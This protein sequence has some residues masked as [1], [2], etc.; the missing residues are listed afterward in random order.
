MQIDFP[1]VDWADVWNP[2]G[3]FSAIEEVFMSQRRGGCDRA[4]ELESKSGVGW[5]A[6]LLRVD[7]P[8]TEETSC[9]SGL[10]LDVYHINND[11]PDVCD[12]TN[13]R[14]TS[15]DLWIT[16]HHSLQESG[17]LNVLHYRSKCTH[18]PI[19]H[20]IPNQYGKNRWL[21]MWWFE[22]LLNYQISATSCP[23]LKIRW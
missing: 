4:R 3:W 2:T 16:G 20:E 8:D 18:L 5:F 14:V 1:S 6:T 12:G 15:P 11:G 17:F 13:S 22:F 10:G 21:R 9:P 7:G 23:S 19:F